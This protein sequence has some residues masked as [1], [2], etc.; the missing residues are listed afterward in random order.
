MSDPAKEHGA[1]WRLIAGAIAVVL[2]ASFFF[3]VLLPVGQVKRIEQTVNDR[4][5]EAPTYTPAPD[6]SVTPNRIA[7]FLAVREEIGEACSGLHSIH[8]QM[9]ETDQKER[10]G[11]LTANDLSRSIGGIF[12]LPR[13]MLG[14]VRARNEALLN[15]EM[16][17][18]E[19]IYIYV[20][21]YHEQLVASLD[22]DSGDGTELIKRRTR[23][24]L[25]QMLRNQLAAFDASPAAPG[26]S[27]AATLI[28]TEIAA[29]ED[30]SH[31]VPWQDGLPTAISA[32]FSPY[33]EQLDRLFCEGVVRYELGQKN[34]RFGAIGE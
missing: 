19:Y 26:G 24:E 27:D 10:D 20:L 33:T 6:G 21:A 3:R 11:D 15:H 23:L 7:T 13:E 1:S 22:P 30:G 28:E 14:L 12:S 34:K 16:G 25:A 9:R 29:L 32:S 4:Y 17:L 5:G 8:A 31:I 18:G 2:F